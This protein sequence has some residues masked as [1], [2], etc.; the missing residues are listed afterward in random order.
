MLRL[1]ESELLYLSTLC[2]STIYK[3]GQNFSTEEKE[4]YETLIKLRN[5]L[6]N[7]FLEESMK[8]GTINTQS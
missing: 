1:N 7:M 8:N 4:E 5:K 6:S 3:K 2:D